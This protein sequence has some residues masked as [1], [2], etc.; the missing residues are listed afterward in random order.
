[1]DHSGL[2][3]GMQGPRRLFHE[4]DDPEEY[5]RLLKKQGCELISRPGEVPIKFRDPSG[6]VAEIVPPGR[7]ASDAPAD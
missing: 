5:L 1:M 3:G 6:I 2:V 4:V 7:Y